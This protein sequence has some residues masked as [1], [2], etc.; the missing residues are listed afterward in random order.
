[1]IA[2]VFDRIYAQNV[3]NGVETRSGPG[4]GPAATQRIRERI[5]EL[6]EWLGV[7]SV[8]D[9]CCGEGWW[10]PDL[11]GYVG[12]DVSAE[13]I[14]RAR[15]LHP[16]REFRVHDARSSVPAADLV[17]CRDAIQHL[18]LPDGCAV[19]DAI[20]ASGSRWLLA[21]TYS[22]G[23]NLA[24]RTGRYYEPDL[25]APPFGLPPAHLLIRDGMDYAQ[26]DVVRDP[27]KF[28]GLWHLT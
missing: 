25:E 23:R 16:G 12:I 3:W 22:P 20:R 28:L 19:V 2:E 4:S 9:A 17:I 8:T 11:P 15:E 5:L 21:S 13:A 10:Q 27:R 18:S 26:A 7:R 24:I 1:M 14:G 6:V